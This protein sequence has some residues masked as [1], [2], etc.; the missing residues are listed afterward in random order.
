MPALK[1]LKKIGEQSKLQAC[2][3]QFDIT[4]PVYLISSLRGVDCSQRRIVSTTVDASLST[5]LLLLTVALTHMFCG[6]IS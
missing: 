2:S 4:S 1:T 3:Q 5:D 6:S